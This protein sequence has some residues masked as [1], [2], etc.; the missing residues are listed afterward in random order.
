MQMKDHAK[1]LGVAIGPGAADHRWTKARDKFIAVCARIP[2]SSQIFFRIL[3]S[4]KIY[5]LSVLSFVESVAE[6][7]AATIAAETLA[8]ERLSARPFHSMPS[9]LLRRGS[10]CGLK[11]EV[12]GVQL[13]SKAAR[14]RVASQSACLSTGIEVLPP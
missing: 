3:V 4:F 12:D 7:D 11:V 9:A 14:F 10:A 6:P 13:T 5:A 2:A 1:Y 8:L